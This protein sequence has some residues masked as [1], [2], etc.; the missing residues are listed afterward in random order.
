MQKVKWYLKYLKQIQKTEWYLKQMLPLTYRTTCVY[1]GQR[2][3]IV[4]KM[5]FGRCFSV[6]DYVVI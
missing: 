2:H 1:D 3:F 6:D 5:W 4:W